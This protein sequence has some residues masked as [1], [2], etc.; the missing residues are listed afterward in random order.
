MYNSHELVRDKK[1][2]RMVKNRNNILFFYKLRRVLSL[3]LANGVGNAIEA[4]EICSIIRSK[5]KEF[6]ST[7]GIVKIF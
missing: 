2:P 1:Q 7:Q 4:I 6:Y 5:T 3:N